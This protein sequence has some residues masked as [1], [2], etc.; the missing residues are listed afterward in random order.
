MV[1]RPLINTVLFPGSKVRTYLCAGRWTDR[2]PTRESSDLRPTEEEEQTRRRTVSQPIRASMQ[3][4][5]QSGP[6]S[7]PALTGPVCDT[8]DWANTATF[9]I[10]RG[11]I[12]RGLPLRGHPSNSDVRKN[13]QN[14]SHPRTR[15]CSRCRCQSPSLWAEEGEE[16]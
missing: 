7:R 2:W 5:N 16:E 4:K 6:V 15:T 9:V 1:S 12:Q 10:F 11:K 13:K 14:N 3:K 8:T